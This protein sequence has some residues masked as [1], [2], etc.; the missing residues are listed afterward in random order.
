[1]L[2][3]VLTAPFVRFEDKESVQ[4]SDLRLL[5]VC[6]WGP[7]EGKSL[8]DAEEE[9]FWGHLELQ[10]PERTDTSSNASSPNQHRSAPF[11]A[12]ENH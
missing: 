4:K 3:E 9:W 1:M 12:K 10:V 8:E 7:Q 6:G 11:A 2:G 5:W